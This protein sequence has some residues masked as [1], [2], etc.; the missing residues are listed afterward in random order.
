M[1]RFGV[2]KADWHPY[3]E[4][5]PLATAQPEPVKVSLYSQSATKRQTG[6]AL[7][8]VSNLS[9]DQSATA[10]VKLD[11]AGLK[12]RATASAKDA[13]SGDALS[14]TNDSLTVPVLPMRMRMVWVE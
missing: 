5:K 12:L 6:R 10:Q 2:S 4:A 14:L 13:L 1:T 3:W 7:L 9:A 8:V 11:R